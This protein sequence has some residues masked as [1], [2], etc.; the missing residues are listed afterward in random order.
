MES[1][2]LSGFHRLR[3][4][5]QPDRDTQTEATLLRKGV[6]LIDL[7]RLL[8]CLAFNSFLPREAK[9]T[10]SYIQ[11]M[12]PR[13][14][15]LIAIHSASIVQRTMHCQVWMVYNQVQSRFIHRMYIL[16]SS[17]YTVRY[18]RWPAGLP[19]SCGA[20]K[21]VIALRYDMLWRKAHL[22]RQRIFH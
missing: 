19:G 3:I 15:C 20:M 11:T 7:T 10:I 16:Q 14:Q 1:K 2:R 21:T 4:P 9:F 17:T 18:P 22:N 5:G 12:C 8:S 6:W 13:Q